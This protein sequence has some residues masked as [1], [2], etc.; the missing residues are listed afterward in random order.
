MKTILAIFVVGL[1]AAHAQELEKERQSQ[2]GTAISIIFDDS[3]SMNEDNKISQAKT[4]F[5]KWIEG[6]PNE[7]KLSLVA[8]NKQLLVPMGSNNKEEVKAKVLALQASGGT[9]LSTRIS[10]TRQAILDR[11]HNVTPYERH[12]VVIF[13]DGASTDDG[14]NEM[15]QTKIRELEKNIIESVA[16]GFHGQGDYMKGVA[17]Q[18]YNAGDTRELLTALKNVAS[19]IDQQSEPVVT[20]EILALMENTSTATAS[21]TPAKK[22][23]WWSW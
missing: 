10:E 3:G 7:T 5:S 2:S 19:E 17:T 20:P 11:R 16:I 23:S 6:I 21:P 15:V 8:L 22:K 13:T 9:P 4:A 14:G 12:V 1:L 18:Y